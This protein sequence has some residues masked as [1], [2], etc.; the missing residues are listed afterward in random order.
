MFHRRPSKRLARAVHCG[1]I[2]AEL[3]AKLPGSQCRIGIVA[4]LTGI[5]WQ[6]HCMATP[7][8]RSRLRTNDMRARHITS[9]TV[10]S[11]RPKPTRA[12]TGRLFIKVAI[13]FSRIG[14]AGVKVLS[15]SIDS[16][17]SRSRSVFI[18]FWDDGSPRSLG[19]KLPPLKLP[20]P[21]ASRAG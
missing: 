19:S 18:M 8:A 11:R 10:A 15:S 16:R 13:G 14:A 5:R 2:R 9:M 7:G 17:S 3:V 1:K 21:G 6:F 12:A 20:L 4:S